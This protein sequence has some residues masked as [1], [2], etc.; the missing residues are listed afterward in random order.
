MLA[1]AH[2][3]LQQA[4]YLY[5]SLP[6]RGLGGSTIDIEFL[7]AKSDKTVA[8]RAATRRARL[9]DAGSCYKAVE[10]LRHRLGWDEVSLPAV[11]WNPKLHLPSVCLRRMLRG[12]DMI[13]MTKDCCS[14]RHSCHG[15][16]DA[17]HGATRALRGGDCCLLHC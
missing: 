16:S 15:R 4:D 10:E 13:V 7:C 14:V 2:I 8:I 3:K 11:I 1:G 17:G 5:A 6:G 12:K 9:P